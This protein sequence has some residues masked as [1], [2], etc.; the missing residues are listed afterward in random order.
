MSYVVVAGGSGRMVMFLLDE[1]TGRAI[2][3]GQ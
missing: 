2:P 3:Y 1:I